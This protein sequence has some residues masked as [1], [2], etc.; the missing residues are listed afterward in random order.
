MLIGVYLDAMNEQRKQIFQLLAVILSA[1]GAAVVL[2]AVMLMSYG[3]SG[4]YVARN[5]LL[6][7]EM[8]GQLDYRDGTNR[9]S[10]SHIESSFFR[11]G[12]WNKGQIDLE[13]YGKVYALLGADRSISGER[14]ELFNR[15]KLLTLSVIVKQ[16]GGE[17]TPFQETD[18]AKNNYRVELVEEK[19]GYAYFDRDNIQEEIFQILGNES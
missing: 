1:I 19:G 16:K 3:P 2:A 15:E 17:D 4:R 9:Y 14:R 7:P 5:L 6:S 13:T 11:E 12:K 18:F 10:F 8:L